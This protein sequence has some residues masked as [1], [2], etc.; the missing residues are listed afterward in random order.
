MRSDFY[1]AVAEKYS[2]DEETAREEVAKFARYWT[3]RDQRGKERWKKEKAFEI[4]RR[5][6]TWF[7]RIE[8]KIRD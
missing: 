3:E 8:A 5:L 1:E 7:S 2:V 6:T 4:P